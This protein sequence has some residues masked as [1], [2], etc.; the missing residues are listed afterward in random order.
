M[1]WQSV[2]GATRYL[3]R[4]IRTSGEEEVVWEQ[5]VRATAVLYA[6][7]PLEP[8]RVYNYKVAVQAVDG[9]SARLTSEG[10]G[11]TLLSA[12]E[13]TRVAE[14]RR[15]LETLALPREANAL[16]LALLYTS[17]DLRAEAMQTL[18]TV[19]RAG[20]RTVAVYTILGHLAR[21]MNLFPE[22][23]AYYTK[24]SQLIGASKDVEARATIQAGLGLVYAALEDAVRARMWFKQAQRSYEQLGDKPRLDELAHHLQ[25]LPTP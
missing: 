4:L 11:F 5:E 20:S 16:A 19:A 14:A 24:A 23:E 6:G 2:P 3:V 1:H 22:A 15:R 21:Q 7:P 9:P 10:L 12:T 13:V 17:Y 25:W 8:H 18:D